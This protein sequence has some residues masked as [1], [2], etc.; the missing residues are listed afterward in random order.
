[1]PSGTLDRQGN[2]EAM[3]SNVLRLPSSRH[4]DNQERIEPYERC[5]LPTKSAS[6][7]PTETILDAAS[8][9]E[10]FILVDNPHRENEGDLVVLADHVTPAAINFMVKYGRGLVCLTLDQ[11]GADRI[12]IELM[13]RRNV[14]VFHT[15]FGISIDARHGI[16]TG[17][18]AADRAHTI[19][20]AIDRNSTEHAFVSPGHIFPLIAC[21]NGVLERDGHTE[22]SV[23]IARLTGATPAAV[24]CE[25][26]NDDGTMARLPDL[27]QF[28]ERHRILVGTIS[29][30]IAYR[31]NQVQAW[32]AR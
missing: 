1:M 12:G 19:K 6:I 26:L 24:I 18:S 22:A 9:G 27:L 4:N 23:D 2:V 5:P 16:T 17:I 10:I 29:D 3:K 21:D 7:S 25:I 20:T 14:D 15:P 8:K 28:A 11:D 32:A 31:Q 13:P 30:L